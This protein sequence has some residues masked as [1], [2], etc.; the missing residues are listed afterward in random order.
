MFNTF[1]TAVVSE[2][3]SLYGIELETDFRIFLKYFYLV[4]NEINKK[5]DFKMFKY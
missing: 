5:I 1:S 2:V 4:R 3:S